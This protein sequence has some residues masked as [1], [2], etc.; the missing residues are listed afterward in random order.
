M[1]GFRAILGIGSI[2]LSSVA[3]AQPVPDSFKVNGP[4]SARRINLNGTPDPTVEAKL[5]MWAGISVGSPPPSHPADEYYFYLDGGG[6][7]GNA[8]VAYV[9]LDGQAFFRGKVDI[10][11]PD[12]GAK[13]KLGVAAS[14]NMNGITGGTTTDGFYGVVGQAT[15]HGW[16]GLFQFGADGNNAAYLGGNGQAASFAG[17]ISV[18]G[19]AT[20]SVLEITGGTDVAEPF[21]VNSEGIPRGAVVIIDDQHPGQLRLCDRPY[22]TRVAGVVSGANGID[23][24]IRL[25][26]RDKAVSSRDIAL[27]GRVYALADASNGPIRPGD[28]L[29]TSPRAGHCMKATDHEKALGSLIGKAMSSLTEGTGMVLVLVSLQ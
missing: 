14:P 21:P 10:G 9:Q 11:T 8:P 18:K 3:I 22:D 25:R 28:L 26:P 13:S 2:F 23:A 6:Y 16:G 5:Y 24:G 29:T 27:S 20:V 19:R 15:T 4:I 17:P 12:P 7:H 1:S